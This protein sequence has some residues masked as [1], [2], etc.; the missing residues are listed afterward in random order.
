MQIDE[1]VVA[2]LG[3]YFSTCKRS[4]KTQ[5]AYRIDLNQMKSHLGAEKN[6]SE[7][8]PEEL[9]GWAADLQAHEYAAVSIRR[10]F[11]T[12]R[13]FF[14]YWVRKGDL[15]KS[16]LWRIRLDLGRAQ[17]LPRSLSPADA[18]RLM[19]EVWRDVETFA[20]TPDNTRDRRFL[21]LRNIAALEVLF[22]TGMRVGELVSLTISDWREDEQMF[23]VRGKGSRQRL[24]FLTDERSLRA[25]QL[26]ARN[27][28]VL[29]VGH[30][31]LFLNFAGK[32]I[33]TQGISRVVAGMAKAADLAH[34]V[35]PHMIRHT[36]ATLL[37]RY[38]ADIRIVQEVLG[39][40]SIATTQRYTHVSK[41]HLVSALQARH[42]NHHLNISWGTTAQALS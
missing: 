28:K 1:A 7:V 30:E 9:E 32:Q 6:L 19:E 2:F 31:A 5:A 27:R 8:A 15:D 20:R 37:L 16:P 14:L 12:A 41:E 36:V 18:K 33:S 29:E 24:A 35:T 42:P 11:A 38:G 39:H 3:G 40:A 10:K 26:Y 17:V 13:V 21:Q 25:V 4:A 22:A 23:I 34:K